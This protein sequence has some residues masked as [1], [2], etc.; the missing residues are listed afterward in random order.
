M[1]DKPVE[2]RKL[3]HPTSQID[4][5]L[6]KL[7]VEIIPNNANSSKIKKYDISKKPEEEFEIRVVIW[8]AEKVLMKDAEGATDGFVKCKIGE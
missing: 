2:Y 3:Y 4:Q 6:I 1:P 8:D 7:W 5:G